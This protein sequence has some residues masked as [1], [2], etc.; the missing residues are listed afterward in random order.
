MKILKLVNGK[1]TLFDAKGSPIS[2]AFGREIMN[3]YLN[4]K[5]DLIVA[6]NKAGKVELLSVKGILT[7]TIVNTGA[8]SA[9]FSGDDIV[10]ETKAGKTE[11]RSQTGILKRTL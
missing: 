7:R 11:L 5:E 10:V 1:I 8:V 6:T 9:R 2:H 3:A 4:D